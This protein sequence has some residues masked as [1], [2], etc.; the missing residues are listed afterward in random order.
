M[1]IYLQIQIQVQMQTNR[2]VMS[3]EPVDP[4]IDFGVAGY[5]CMFDEYTAGKYTS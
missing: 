1:Q 2:L 5:I 3:R 4:W